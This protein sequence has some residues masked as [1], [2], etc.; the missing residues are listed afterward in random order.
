PP[1]PPPPLVPPSI[2]SSGLYLGAR[3]NPGNVKNGDNDP[4]GTNE[5]AQLPAFNA[6]LGK[7][8][9]IL[10]VFVPF[11]AAIP[12]TTLAAFEQNGS[13]PLVDLGCANLEEVTSGVDDAAITAE[14]Q[15]LKTFARPIMLRWYW[16]MNKNDVAHTGRNCDAYNNGANFMAAWRHIK[17]IFTQVGATNV[18]FVWCPSANNQYTRQYYPG[19][20]YVDW[21][22][23]D[24]FNRE[25]PNAST[26]VGVF[27]DFYNQ[28]VGR[29]KPMMVGSTGAYA[30]D[31][32]A[33]FQGM[34]QDI[35]TQMPQMK[36]IIYFDAPGD[37]GDFSLH[38]V[39]L[40]AFKVLIH[41]AY[42]SYG[43]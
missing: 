13:I 8:V 40:E 1:P 24:G 18:A 22:A 3:V 28:W 33:Y 30:V 20:N 27:G 16:E 17:D 39:G 34:Q 12:L 42:F 10:P 21:I 11:T 19:N 6:A 31:Q 35:P 32:P 7:T 2:P 43:S 29:G 26:F 15:S 38:D 4:Y 37:N 23:A 25:K 41:S 14:A 36:A 5:L 9:A